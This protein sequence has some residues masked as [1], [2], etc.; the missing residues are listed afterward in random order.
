MVWD[1][2]GEA[3]MRVIQRKGCE[4]RKGRKEGGRR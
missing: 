3:G 4:G 1:K 2:E